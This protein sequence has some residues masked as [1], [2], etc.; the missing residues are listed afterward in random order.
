MTV[1]S[2]LHVS[3]GRRTPSNAPPLERKGA[4]GSVAGRVI[5]GGW[6]ALVQNEALYFNIEALYFE[7]EPFCLNDEAMFQEKG[8]GKK[9]NEAFLKLPATE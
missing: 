2:P 7:N 1:D 4:G 3:A 6:Q 8:A 5:P 9:E